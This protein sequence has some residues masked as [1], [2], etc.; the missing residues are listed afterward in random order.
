VRRAALLATRDPAPARAVAELLEE[1]FLVD[2]TAAVLDDAAVLATP[3]LPTPDAIHLASARRVGVR[4]LVSYD[5]R[6]L[7]AAAASGL[8]TIS[9]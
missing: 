3:P 2:V 4:V 5:R 8:A 7:E 1:C 6:Q 9:P